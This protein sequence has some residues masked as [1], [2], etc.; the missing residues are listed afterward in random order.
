LLVIPERFAADTIAREGA[1]GAA[2]ID[3]LPG[4]TEALMRRWDL[5]A[6]GP[7]MHGY[8]GI[9]VPVSRAG[10]Q[11]VLKV[12]WVD[13]DSEHEAD[14]LA[15]WEGRGAE[16]LFDFDRSEGALLLERL[17]AHTRLDSLAPDAAIEVAGQLLRRLAIP[18]PPWARSL[19]EIAE[20][21]RETIPVR[22]ESL[23][24]PFPRP[25]LDRTSGVL[26]DLIPQRSNLL[27][28]SDLHYGNVLA[29]RREPW[30]VIDPKVVGGDLEFATAQ[31][32]W[33]PFAAIGSRQDLD[34]RMGNLVEAAELDDQRARAW[35]LVR[36]V[37]YWLWAL[38][39]GFTEDPARCS[40]LVG[41]V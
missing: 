16:R 35:T 15:A 6:D 2:W 11:F 24:N 7:I 27:A 28:N 9:V 41:W 4:R 3:E 34:R 8:V 12:S 31:L 26:S 14:A 39:Q 10:D 33:Q 13:A 38:E 20:E 17:D 29:G 36:V 1:A 32:L 5:V 23:A 22:W 30:L 21:L 37:D 40:D 19:D 25:I 18:A